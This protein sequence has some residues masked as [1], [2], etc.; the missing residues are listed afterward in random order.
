M[1][2]RSMEAI[3]KLK[4]ILPAEQIRQLIEFG[5]INE[6]GEVLMGMELEKNEAVLPKE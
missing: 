4:S 2:R 6:K 1:I 5:T 3:E